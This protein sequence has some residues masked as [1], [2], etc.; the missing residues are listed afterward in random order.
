MTKINE[1][2]LSIHMMPMTSFASTLRGQR[3]RHHLVRE[4]IVSDISVVHSC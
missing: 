4:G 2:K 1:T 3:C